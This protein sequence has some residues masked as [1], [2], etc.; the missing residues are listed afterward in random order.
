[1]IKKKI[2]NIYICINLYIIDSL[3]EVKF[4]KIPQTKKKVAGSTFCF[5]H[6]LFFFPPY[7]HLWTKK[8]KKS[9]CVWQSIG[10]WRW[11]LWKCNS[12][13]IS[14]VCSF[15]CAVARWAFI[16]KNKCTTQSSFF[17]LFTSSFFPIFFFFCCAGILFW[18]DN[19]F[20]FAHIA[21]PH[22]HSKKKFLRSGNFLASFFVFALLWTGDQKKEKKFLFINNKKR[23]GAAS[24]S[25][26]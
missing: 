23:F 8:K 4:K 10:F 6:Y 22:T 18:N 17:F 12:V 19:F 16:F 2:Q 1:M 7:H 13:E 3:A 20:F 26:C 11:G 21:T 24:R 9:V 25:F 5:Y 14:H 15:E